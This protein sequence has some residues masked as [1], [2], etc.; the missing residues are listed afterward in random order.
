LQRSLNGVDFVSVGD[1]TATGSS[2]YGYN[3][4]VANVPSPVYYYRLRMV[5]RDGN[6]KLS[7]IVKINAGRTAWFAEANPNPFGNRLNIR[8]QSPE[9]TNARVLVTDMSGRQVL[10]RQV[11][12]INGVNMVSLP[13][14]AVLESGLYNVTIITASDRYSIRAVKVK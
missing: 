14:A 3:D 1:V 6:F 2:S 10:Q 13:E 9:Q 5:D 7:E 4:P 11:S 12:L 8:I